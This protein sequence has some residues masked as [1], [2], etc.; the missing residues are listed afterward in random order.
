VKHVGVWLLHDEEDDNTVDQ[1]QKSAAADHGLSSHVNLNN[2][3]II[4]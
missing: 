4:I 2:N 1:Q 3:I